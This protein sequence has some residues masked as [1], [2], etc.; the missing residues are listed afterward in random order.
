[1]DAIKV[2]IREF[3]AGLPEYIASS[4]AVAITDHGQT[5]GYFI[6]AE[7][8]GES[9]IAALRKAGEAFDQSIGAK[10]IDI[11]EAVAEFDALRKKANPRKKSGAKVA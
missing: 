4:T 1:M 9:D 10:G 11:E 6:P 8:Y 3:R 7:K 2:G 5:V